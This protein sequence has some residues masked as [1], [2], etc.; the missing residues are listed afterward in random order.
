MY[1]IHSRLASVCLEGQWKE[2]EIGGDNTTG[3]SHEFGYGLGEPDMPGDQKADTDNPDIMDARGTGV[4]A[5]YTYSPNSGDSTP[6]PDD[7]NFNN[8]VR[9]E[10]RKVNQSDIDKLNSDANTTH[11][12]TVTN[13]YHQ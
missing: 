5:D 2:D 1:T 4:C 8:S 11:L 12:G 9:P 10:T 13:T 3:E 6:K 7:P